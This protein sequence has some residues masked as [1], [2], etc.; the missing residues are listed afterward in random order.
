[1]I[2]RKPWLLLIDKKTLLSILLF[3][4][5][6]ALLDILDG[7]D[8][9]LA[10]ISPYQNGPPT[11]VHHSAGTFLNANNADGRPVAYDHTVTRREDAHRTVRAEDSAGPPQLISPS[12][13]RGHVCI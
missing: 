13:S 4:L 1:M 6:T 5:I 9:D 11:I 12:L 8:A 2:P 3:S 7:V 10:L